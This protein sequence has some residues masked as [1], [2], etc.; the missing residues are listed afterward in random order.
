VDEDVAD[1]LGRIESKLDSVI[2]MLQGKKGG[3]RA[4]GEG[5]VKPSDKNFDDEM[6]EM[7]E[8]SGRLQCPECG[9]LKVKEMKDKNTVLSMSGGIAIY[10]TKHVCSQCGAEW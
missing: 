2:E 7:P 10:R 6:A 3:A 8:S 4:G 1:A 9:S 5:N